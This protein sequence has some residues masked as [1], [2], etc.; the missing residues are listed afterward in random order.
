MTM[1]R[2]FVTALAL[3]ALVLDAGADVRQRWTLDFDN[4]K[5]DTF[6]YRYRSGKATNVWFVV[7]TVKNAGE[8]EA[9]L[10]FDHSLRTDRGKIV[11]QG[12]YPHIVAQ[13]IRKLEGLGPMDSAELDATVEK[14]QGE[15]KYLDASKV[16]QKGVLAPGQEFTGIATFEGVPW[17]FKTLELL[18]SGLSD[19]VRL[20]EH[21][22]GESPEEAAIKYEFETRVLR[23]LYTHEGDEFYAQFD[24]IEFL[25]RDWINISLGAVGDRRTLELLVEALSLEDE[26]ARRSAG[27]LLGKL[28][29]AGTEGGPPDYGYDGSKSVA[30]NADAIRNWRSWVN[31]H[32]FNLTW[33]ES[34]MRFVPKK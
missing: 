2:V 34:N 17:G 24:M 16:R 14:L 10:V 31:Q 25:K 15:G 23:A 11:H 27:E 26:V 1:N 19:P 18:T 30:D 28:T 8:V 7:Y 29:G 20:K 21:K 32:K 9:P 12:W 4:Q 22:L 33:D 3:L 13:I 5:P 6:T